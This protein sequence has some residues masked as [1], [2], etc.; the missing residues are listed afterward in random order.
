MDDGLNDGEYGEHDELRHNYLK[1]TEAQRNEKDKLASTTPMEKFENVWR[2]G[3][4]S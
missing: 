4:G 2:A 1:R 3:S